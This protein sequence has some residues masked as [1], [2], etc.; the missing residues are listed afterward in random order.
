M[1]NP[2]PYDEMMRL[3][4]QFRVKKRL[5]PPKPPLWEI[6]SPHTTVDLPRPSQRGSTEERSFFDDLAF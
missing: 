3:I 4:K 6:Y 2:L 5:A 1:M